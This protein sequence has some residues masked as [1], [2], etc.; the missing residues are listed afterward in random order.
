MTKFV[1]FL[2][3]AVKNTQHSAQEV[4]RLVPML[5]FGSLESGS[6]IDW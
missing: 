4:Y 5:N 3:S 1:R 6:D 2:I